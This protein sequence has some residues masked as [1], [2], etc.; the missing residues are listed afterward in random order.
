MAWKSVLRWLSL[1][2]VQSVAA[3]A[4]TSPSSPSPSLLVVNGVLSD[5]A[6]AGVNTQEHDLPP[7]MPHAYL[8]VKITR[9]PLFLLAHIRVQGLASWGKE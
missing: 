8:V 7:P 6:S 1:P 2:E 3:H 4:A 5:C 9:P